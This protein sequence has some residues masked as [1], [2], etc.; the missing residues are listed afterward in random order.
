[1]E[2][3]E[4]GIHYAES[5]LDFY[6]KEKNRA[7]FR[8]SPLSMALLTCSTWP[9]IKSNGS[10]YG[11]LPFL[12]LFPSSK[13]EPVLII[14]SRT[15]PSPQLLCEVYS[16]LPFH[17]LSCVPSFRTY[18]LHQPHSTI[19]IALMLLSISQRDSTQCL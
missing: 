6:G 11:C 12:I 3:E 15:Q 17:W 5:S 4:T 13:P 14:L 7:A 19:K 8:C 9:F 16:H 2:G 18:P 1:M 10:T